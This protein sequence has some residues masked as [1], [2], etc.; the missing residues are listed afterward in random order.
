MFVL[1]LVQKDTDNSENEKPSNI[2]HK[3]HFH[4]NDQ[5]FYCRYKCHSNNKVCIFSAS[6]YTISR[7]DLET[8]SAVCYFRVFILYLADKA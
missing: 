4:V 5:R 8:F 7:L 6:V 1:D 3:T 2:T